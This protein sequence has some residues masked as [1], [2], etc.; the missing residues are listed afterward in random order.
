M[1]IRKWSLKFSNDLRLKYN[2]ESTIKCYEINVLK[3]L[4]HF[5]NETEPKAI[6]NEKI[7]EYLLSFKTLN[8]RKQ[9]LC[10]V[11]L[12]YKLTIGMK[13][14]VSKIPYPKKENK[15]PRVI[16]K[17]YLIK[18]ISEIDN[19]KHKA[20]LSV[21][22]SVGLRVSEVINLKIK[23]IDSK[24]NLIAIRN[25]KGG[26]DRYVPLSEKLLFLLRKY[27]QQYKPVEYLF[28]GQNKL[29]YTTSSCNQLVKKYLG[30]SYHFHLLRHSCFTT[31]LETGT[32]IRI[33]QKIAGHKSSKTTEIYTHISNSFL[34]QTNT[35]I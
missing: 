19:L 11:K 3:F 22:Y 21:A 28:N 7:K 33:I 26:N 16:E 9:N 10:A 4:N 20:I 2:S 23:D 8:T 1:N 12:F 31:M 14:K 15:L 25:A 34:S 13:N 32:D 27:F 35:P 17:N 24:R 29:K 5:E 18:T 6:P 30:A